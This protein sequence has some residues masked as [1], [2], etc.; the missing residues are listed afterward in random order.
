MATGTGAPPSSSGISDAQMATLMAAMRQ[1]MKDELAVMKRELSTEREAANEKLVMKIKLEKIPSFRKKGHEKQFRHNEEVRLKLSE[2]RSTLDE[3]PVAVEK[4]KQLLEEG[5]KLINERQKHIRIVDRSD[6]G[7]ATV[8]EYVEDEL[9]DNED[10]EKRLLRADA[11]AGK[12]LNSAQIG[13]RGSARKNFPRRN[14]WSFQ[15]PRNIPG[16]LAAGASQFIPQPANN[17]YSA[18]AA[19]PQHGFNRNQAQAGVNPS[20]IGPCFERGMPG[21]YRKY[22]PK[23]VGKLPGGVSK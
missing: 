12:K 13:G 20:A 7:R 22:C 10:D 15:G 3:Q 14:P 1:G 23:L 8:E 6:N 4:A 17:M 21:H 18:V 16:G 2:A 19:S 9:A 5:E 11:R